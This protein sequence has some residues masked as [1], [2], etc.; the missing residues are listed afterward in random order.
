MDLK[1]LV[2][3][4]EK[5]RN[6]DIHHHNTRVII[7]IINVIIARTFAKRSAEYESTSV[8]YWSSLSSII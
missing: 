5:H 4:V 1:A 7:L 3:V 2:V 6:N 8:K